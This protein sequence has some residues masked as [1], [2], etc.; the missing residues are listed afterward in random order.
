MPSFWFFFLHRAFFLL[1]QTD[2]KESHPSNVILVSRSLCLAVQRRLVLPRN[3]SQVIFFFYPNT[4]SVCQYAKNLPFSSRIHRLTV[5]IPLNTPQRLLHR[6]NLIIPTLPRLDAIGA[7]FEY[8]GLE[9]VQP[10][11]NY[12]PLEDELDLGRISHLKQLI[13]NT[14]G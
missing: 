13:V 3:L 11:D 14:M 4:T 8:Y 12:K 10:T 2:K 5:H 9:V 1:V 6:L 7:P